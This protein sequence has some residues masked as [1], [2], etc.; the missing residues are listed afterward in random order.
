MEPQINGGLMMGDKVTFRVTVARMSRTKMG[1]TA[2]L[3]RNEIA[4]SAT[5]CPR[6]TRSSP[7]LFTVFKR[8]DLPFERR[9]AGEA[10]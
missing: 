10:W 9:E 7:S 4:I 6:F 2:P 3:S 5:S 1:N 8:R